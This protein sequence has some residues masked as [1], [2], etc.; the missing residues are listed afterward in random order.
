MRRLARRLKIDSVIKIEFA[1][2]VTRSVVVELKTESDIDVDQLQR[3]RQ[4]YTS[5]DPGATYFVLA[6]G[7][8]R[9]V[10]NCAPGKGDW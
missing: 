7:A 10:H 8:G 4:A 3:T 2:K 9:S 1:G 6:L 5:E